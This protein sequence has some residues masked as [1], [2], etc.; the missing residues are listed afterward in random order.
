MNV[1]EDIK[2]SPQG[3]FCV[4]ITSPFRQLSRED[5]VDKD[6]DDDLSPPIP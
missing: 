6:D 1:V 2:H 5:E 4:R 3:T